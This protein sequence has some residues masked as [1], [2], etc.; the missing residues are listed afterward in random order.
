[1]NENTALVV[2]EGVSLEFW[3]AAQ[4]NPLESIKR[5]MLSPYRST[6]QAMANAWGNPGCIPGSYGYALAQLKRDV[7]TQ[8][9][10]TVG[11][12][13]QSWEVVWE[14]STPDMLAVAIIPF[15]RPRT[16][17][18]IKAKN[19]YEKRMAADEANRLRDIEIDPIF[20]VPICGLTPAYV[21]VIQEIAIHVLEWDSR[22][23]YIDQ[24]NWA[25][26]L[27]ILNRRAAQA[28]GRMNLSY[29]GKVAALR[30]L[31]YLQVIP[32]EEI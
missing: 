1:M 25:K 31:N 5:A 3:V 12:P 24:Q 9:A 21:G 16:Q 30:V 7:A 4:E 22:M 17:A 14:R 11:L 19:D 28:L 2:N 15:G 8:T 18:E 20:P 6:R 23:N 10:L 13:L 27:T 32:Q 26:M 29:E